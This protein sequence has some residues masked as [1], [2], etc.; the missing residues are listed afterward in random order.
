MH[1]PRTWGA[2]DGHD[3]GWPLTHGETTGQ[4]GSMASTVRAKNVVWGSA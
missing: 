2:S 3:G 1:E 4:A